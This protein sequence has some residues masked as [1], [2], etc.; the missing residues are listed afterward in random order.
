VQKEHQPN[1]IYCK[2]MKHERWA[3]Y[4]A[5]FYTIESLSKLIKIA[6]FFSALWLITLMWS[7]F[8]LFSNHHPPAYALVKQ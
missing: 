2:M 7:D 4:F 6:E 5:T 1:A 3:K 8:F